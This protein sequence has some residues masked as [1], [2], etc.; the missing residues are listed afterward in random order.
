M[1]KLI[2]TPEAGQLRRSLLTV[3]SHKQFISTI[4]HLLAIYHIYQQYHRRPF[5]FHDVFSYYLYRPIG[6]FNILSIVFA[7]Y[8]MKVYNKRSGTDIELFI[9][10]DRLHDSALRFAFYRNIKVV[11]CFEDHSNIDFDLYQEIL[12]EINPCLSIEIQNIVN[13]MRARY[14][15][16]DSVVV[17]ALSLLRS[18]AINEWITA[19]H[20]LYPIRSLIYSI[21]IKSS[22]LYVYDSY[23]LY[24][25]GHLGYTWDSITKIKTANPSA[26]FLILRDFGSEVIY[27]SF[28]S[29]EYFWSDINIMSL[30]SPFPLYLKSVCRITSSNTVEPYPNNEILGE[31]DLAKRR[32]IP[33]QRLISSFYPISRQTSRSIK[34]LLPSRF[35]ND[36]FITLHPRTHYFKGG[37]EG[38]RDTSITSFKG[39]CLKL[40]SKGFNLVCFGIDNR[41]E[42]ESENFIHAN[43]N[44]TNGSVDMINLINES[45]LH[46]GSNSGTTHIAAP[47]DVPLIYYDIPWSYRLTQNRSTFYHNKRTIYAGSFLSTYKWY[48]HMADVYSEESILTD[49]IP[50]DTEYVDDF[51]NSSLFSV[52]SMIQSKTL[53][54]RKERHSKLYISSHEY[55]LAYDFYLSQERLRDQ[56]FPFIHPVDLVNFY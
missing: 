16:F 25:T 48:R 9:S 26:A 23:N 43:S 20:I 14:T 7:Y 54:S 56:R 29:K 15:S 49:S 13:H 27:S 4:E 17:S 24:N 55:R 30:F 37:N 41:L 11:S 53:L 1:Q 51:N 8:Y 2:S 46:I 39:L 12:S 10:Y 44:N 47:L 22:D 35:C 21:A 6:A 28:T 36:G 19:N 34:D 33:S 52:V 32:S 38:A 18:C 3:K 40:I 31:Q 5:W 50:Q 45:F 42:L